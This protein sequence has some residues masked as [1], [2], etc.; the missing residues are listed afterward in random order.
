MPRVRQLEDP[1]ARLGMGLRFELFVQDVARSV[2]FY[3]ATLGRAP[4]RGGAS[5][6]SFVTTRVSP[7]RQTASASYSPGRFQLVPVGPWST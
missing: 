6:S 4:G 5:R 2:R 1:E 3:R 7:N